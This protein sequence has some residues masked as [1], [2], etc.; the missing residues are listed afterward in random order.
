MYTP[1]PSSGTKQRLSKRCFLDGLE[2]KD[3]APPASPWPHKGDSS[4]FIRSGTLPLTGTCFRNRLVSHTV[5][6][7]KAA[8]LQNS[9]RQPAAASASRRRRRRRARRRRRRRRR[10][11]C[12]AA[13]AAARPPLR[14]R[15]LQRQRHSGLWILGLYL[16]PQGGPESG[17][18]S[19]PKSGPPCG[20]EKG[21]PNGPNLGTA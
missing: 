10:R 21:S 20:P 11:R 1:T 16:G 18:Q 13:A 7:L 6:V 12:T 15:R 2:H 17:S 14:R 8:G 9:G 3:R 5:C 19:G 4:R